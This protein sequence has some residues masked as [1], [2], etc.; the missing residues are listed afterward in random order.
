MKKE[1]LNHDELVEVLKSLL[2]A[3]PDSYIPDEDDLQLIDE[4]NQLEKETVWS[5]EAYVDNHEKLK[6][7]GLDEKL[8]NELEWLIVFYLENRKEEF[9]SSKF[10]VR[11]KEHKVVRRAE[12]EYERKLELEDERN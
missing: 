12:M 2:D 9:L 6:A 10:Y 1:K 5:F 3:D 4:R 11:F 8:M 7:Y